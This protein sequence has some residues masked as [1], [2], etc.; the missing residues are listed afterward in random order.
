[1]DAPVLLFADIGAFNAQVMV[2]HRDWIHAVV[3][4]A[5]L[6]LLIQLQR[7]KPATIVT[8]SVNG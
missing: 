4:A 8:A 3:I 6:V 5:L 7:A 1:M 2:L